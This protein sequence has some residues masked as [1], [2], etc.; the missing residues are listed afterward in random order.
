MCS[1]PGSVPSG[2]PGSGHAGSGLAVTPNLNFPEGTLMQSNGSYDYQ[3][4][5]GA[6]G[7]ESVNQRRDQERFWRALGKRIRKGAK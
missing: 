6:P 1:Y 4:E 2:Q 5:A 3:S 7:S